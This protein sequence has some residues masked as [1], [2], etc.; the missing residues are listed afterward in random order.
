MRISKKRQYGPL[1]PQ[2]RGHVVVSLE[3][4]ETVRMLAHYGNGDVLTVTNTRPI[5][6]VG[7]LARRF[8]YPDSSSLKDTIDKLSKIAW[9]VDVTGMAL[10]LGSPI[11][12][13]IILLG[14][15][16]A[17]DKLPLTVQQVEGEIRSTFPPSAVD[18]NLKALRKGREA[19]LGLN[20]KQ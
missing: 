7:V 16:L 15:L 1:I 4:L 6:P 8:D 20:S 12:A 17:I 19:I 10:D 18:L 13:N 5:Q 9:L 11:V 3:P 14:S 2:G